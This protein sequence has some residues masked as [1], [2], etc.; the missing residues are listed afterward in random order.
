MRKTCDSETKKEKE[1]RRLSKRNQSHTCL[2]NSEAVKVVILS[3]V[4]EAIEGIKAPECRRVLPLREA[5]MPP[6]PPKQI[7]Y[8]CRADIGTEMKHHHLVQGRER[9]VKRC[10]PQMYTRA[11]CKAAAHNALADSVRG[12]ARLFH[13]LWQQRFVCIQA[14]GV[15]TAKWKLEA[16]PMRVTARHDGTAGG[17]AHL[18]VTAKWR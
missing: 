17:A 3:T 9:V 7:T 6:V 2:V 5:K 8:T 15:A 18:P 16:V 14:H 11:S 13:V 10:N 12:V 4:V 1:T